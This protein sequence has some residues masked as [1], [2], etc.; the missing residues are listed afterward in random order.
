MRFAHYM[1]FSKLLYMITVFD[2]F[3]QKKEPQFSIWGKIFNRISVFPVCAQIDVNCNDNTETVAEIVYP[4][5]DGMTLVYTDSARQALGFVDITDAHN[6]VPAGIVSLQGEP[7]S[8]AVKGNYALA[9]VNTGD[10]Y[11][12]PSGILEVVGTFLNKITAIHSL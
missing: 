11:T 6:P 5:E 12:N 9:A 10:D 2:C 3:L 4:A 7:T 1:F 8:V